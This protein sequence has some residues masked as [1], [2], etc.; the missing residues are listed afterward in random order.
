MAFQG[1]RFYIRKKGENFEDACLL[2][3]YAYSAAEICSS[4]S[5]LQAS[6]TLILQRC[7][8][9]LIQPFIKPIGLRMVGTAYPLLHSCPIKETGI[10]SIHKLPTLIRKDY[11]RPT[12]SAEC[13]EQKPCY[14][15]CFLRKNI[16]C[17]WPLREII[18]EGDYILIPLFRL[19]KGT[20][21]IY[22]HSVPYFRYRNW[23][24]PSS[25]FVQYSIS[26]LTF[27]SMPAE[28]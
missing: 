10:V 26:A 22:T 20:N 13:V 15:C 3:L 6:T 1:R 12:M 11:L 21:T 27:V 18:T 8:Q 4:Q 23:V 14:T 24:K 7:D 5:L 2:I 16:S 28:L 17:F 9:G 25:R 19:R